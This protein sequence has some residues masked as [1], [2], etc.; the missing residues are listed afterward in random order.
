[1]V[2]AA[3]GYLLLLALLR[4]L[5]IRQLVPALSAMAAVLTINRIVNGYLKSLAWGGGG[6]VFV[7]KLAGRV[8]PDSDF[9]ALLERLSGQLLHMGQ[10][11]Q[12][13]AILGLI[14]ALGLITAAVRSK[15]LR[16]AMSNP[17][18]GTVVLTMVSSGGVLVASAA[19]KVHAAHGS[20]GRGCRG[21]P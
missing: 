17:L 19:S 8:I 7:H 9:L 14:G 16:A 21:G 11:S 12:G 18:I 20:V 6:D 2:A 5:T 4:S 10:A 3:I 1:V 13:F 15:S